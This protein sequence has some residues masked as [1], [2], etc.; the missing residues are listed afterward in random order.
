MLSCGIIL[1]CIKAAFNRIASMNNN[2]ILASILSIRSCTVFL[3]SFSVIF[4]NNSVLFSSLGCYGF[5]KGIY[6]V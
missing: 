2:I 5:Q 3:V 1:K 6:L 4:F